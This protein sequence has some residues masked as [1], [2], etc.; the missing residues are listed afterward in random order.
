MHEGSVLRVDGAGVEGGAAFAMALAR[1]DPD[2]FH[3]G[4]GYRSAGQERVIHL[5]WHRILREQALEELLTSRTERLPC[6]LVALWLDPAVEAVLKHLV[7]RIAARFGQGL[8]G[9]AYGFGEAAALFDPTSAALDDP[10]AAFTC[11]T[12]VLQLLRSVGVMLLDP[13]RWRA[14]TAE[15]LAWQQQKGRELVAWVDR[16]VHQDLE[17]TR[18]RVEKDYRALRFRPLDVAG[19]ALL[20]PALRPASA[21]E[22]DPHA[23]R[24]ASLLG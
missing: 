13:A 9:P 8:D 23:A 14:P 18:E 20:D 6:A 5:A 7:R 16:V 17:Q 10:D 12:F 15:D 21:A 1:V 19:A 3:L 24:L 11:A 4:L 22:V 2:Q